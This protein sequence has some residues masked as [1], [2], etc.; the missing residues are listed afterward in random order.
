MKLKMQLGVEVF[1]EGKRSAR[2]TPVDRRVDVTE[3]VG[4]I[5]LL[6]AG[7]ADANDMQP[8]DGDVDVS[9]GKATKALKIPAL[10]FARSFL[11]NLDGDAN[12]FIRISA[13]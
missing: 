6:L 1:N 10:D 8:G 13:V 12:V 5:L 7:V 3:E 11:K 9:I 4:G 2:V